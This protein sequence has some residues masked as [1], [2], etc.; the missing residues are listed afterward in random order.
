MDLIRQTIATEH[1]FAQLENHPWPVSA[2][3]LQD[4]VYMSGHKD[5]WE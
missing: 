3:W 4:V 5:M 2:E 1:F